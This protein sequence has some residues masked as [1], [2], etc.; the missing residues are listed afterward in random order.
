M[1]VT[2]FYSSEK[3]GSQDPPCITCSIYLCGTHLPAV[4]KPELGSL[5]ATP[6]PIPLPQPQGRDRGA[7]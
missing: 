2:T 4:L 5:L 7:Y 6:E 3:L 1:S